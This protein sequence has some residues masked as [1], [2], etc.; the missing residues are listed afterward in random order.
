MAL[1]NFFFM[2]FLLMVFFVYFLCSVIFSNSANQNKIL[3]FVLIVSSYVFVGY[4]NIYC[5][6]L[7]MFI[8]FI[9]YYT[10]LLLVKYEEKASIISKTSI[11][12]LLLILGFFK[13][14]NFFV[15]SFSWLGFNQV[16]I[17]IF[18]PLGISFYVFSAISYIVDITR[19]KYSVNKSSMEV[20]LYISYFPKLLS[21]P[22]VRADDFFKQLPNV[23]VLKY[24]N[25][26]VG[27]QIFVVGLFKKMVLADRLSVFVDDVFFCPMAY[28]S[29]T[30]LWATF[31][32]TLQIYFDFSGYSD[33]AIGVSKMFGFDFKDNFN[34]PYLSKNVTEFW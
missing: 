9:C 13:Y 15:T 31:S 19:K 10:S 2:P 12:I 22:I 20:F 23:S 5:A 11:I 1:N 6:L 34:Y 7:L 8:S 4:A 29:L 28:D 16:T 18:L 14:F 3:Y 30:V 32:Y 26:E 27:I 25:I 21:G 17:K 24:Q 33:M